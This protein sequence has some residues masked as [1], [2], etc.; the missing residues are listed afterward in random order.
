MVKSPKKRTKRKK[1]NVHS[2][3]PDDLWIVSDRF[4]RLS[5]DTQEPYPYRVL[6]E[7]RLWYNARELAMRYYGCGKENVKVGRA[8]TG[9]FLPRCYMLL[10]L[11]P[12]NELLEEI[13]HVTQERDEEQ[14]KTNPR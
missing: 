10:R 4:S 9:N 6:I 8:P 7:Q 12:H 1:M 11:G 3:D 14:A 5:T 13:I 2:P